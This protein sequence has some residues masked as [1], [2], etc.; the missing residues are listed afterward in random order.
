[1][2]LP[3]LP[4]F[5]TA[6]DNASTGPKLGNSMQHFLD[7]FRIINGI[8]FFSGVTRRFMFKG[9]DIIPYYQTIVSDTNFRTVGTS[10]VSIIGAA[11]LQ[12]PSMT[13]FNI[14]NETNIT[15]LD[16]VSVFNSKNTD[17]TLR[18]DIS[19]VSRNL[20]YDEINSSASQITFNTYAETVKQRL[21]NI[22]DTE[23]FEL[24]TT[25]L[26]NLK[27]VSM[28]NDAMKI[29]DMSLF[30]IL[31]A[32]V[33]SNS[34]MTL[35]T[36]V[37][38][39][40]IAVFNHLDNINTFF[41][42]MK[43]DG[44]DDFNQMII[45]INEK[46]M[47][48]QS[49]KDSIK[50]VK[51]KLYTLMSRDKNYTK[52]LS[53][54]RRQFY[55]FLVLLIIICLIFGFVLLSKNID[56]NNKNYIVGSLAIG[57]LV[58]QVLAQLLGMIKRSRIK[59]RFEDTQVVAFADP[60][61]KPLF[62]SES[63]TIN[64]STLIDIPYVLVN[65]VD[66]YNENMTYEVKSEYYES[67]TDKQTQDA[68][69]LEQLHKENETQKYLHQLKNSLTYFKINETREYTAYVTYGLILVSMM[70]ILYLS[71]LNNTIDR[72]IFVVAG[73]LSIVLYITYILLSIKSIMLRDQYDWDRVNWTMNTIR[74]NSNQERCTLPGR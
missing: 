42:T 60:L 55:F 7:A 15:V 11:E 5:F 73:T 38:G 29:Y 59:E 22:L 14:V 43:V 37:A 68:K 49:H 51:E 67:I 27:G 47:D 21:K 48:I 19:K 44:A 16:V 62:V 4:A 33:D 25:K 69:M 61:Q 34:S 31:M 8:P 70:S 65:F 53:Y 20:T 74:G 17:G 24:Y 13:V 12:M 57:I 23:V 30:D 71:V 41:T 35:G 32:F 2:S 10:N 1:M 26:S 54:R 9:V 50:Q 63:T 58:I 39:R 40:Q 45:K 56:L 66:K 64:D 6:L 28:P 72:N 46:Q 52:V 18:Y 3:V 36:T